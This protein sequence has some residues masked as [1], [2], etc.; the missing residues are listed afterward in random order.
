MPEIKEILQVGIERYETEPNTHELYFI[1]KM[2]DIHRSGHIITDKPLP[3]KEDRHPIYWP[4]PNELAFHL[5][6]WIQNRK[7]KSILDTE[8]LINTML[9]KPGFKL[10]DLKSLNIYALDQQL[11]SFD[12]RSGI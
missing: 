8:S 9:N 3:M 1:E 7:K 10:E 4:F 2:Y 6:K 12:D 11:A 5:Y